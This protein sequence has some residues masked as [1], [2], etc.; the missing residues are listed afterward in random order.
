MRYTDE[1][2]LRLI[3]PEELELFIAHDRTFRFLYWLLAPTRARR[4]E[5]MA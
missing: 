1:L 5:V 2:Q 4:A 3:S